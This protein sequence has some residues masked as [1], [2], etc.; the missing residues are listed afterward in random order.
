MLGLT[1]PLSQSGA[2]TGALDTN[3]ERAFEAIF[4]EHYDRVFRILLRL[5]GDAAHAEELANEVFWRLSR[6]PQSRLFDSSVAGWLYKTAAHAGIDAL[7]ASAHRKHYEQAAAR[8]AHHA[9]SS[10]TGALGTVLR[11]E[12]RR[13]V[14]RTL[15]SMKPA[16]AQILLL[17]ANGSS[18]KELAAA[19]G[20]AVSSVGTLLNRAEEEFRKRYLKLT[21]HKENV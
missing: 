16:Q 11:E 2:R 8:E 14:Q 4:L 20:V 19:M 21:R 9:G 7:R 3:A 10:E 12:N 1:Q 17:R 6:Q 5:L 13:A 18:Y 15:V